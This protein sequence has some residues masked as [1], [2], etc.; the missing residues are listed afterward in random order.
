M[1]DS[2]KLRRTLGIGASV[3]A[4]G[5]GAGA[6]V[7]GIATASNADCQGLAHEVAQLQAELHGPVSGYTKTRIIQQIVQDEMQMGREGC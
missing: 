5:A 1:K 6:L 3:L 7:P 4:L 2:G